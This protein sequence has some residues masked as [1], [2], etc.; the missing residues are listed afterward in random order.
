MPIYEYYC[1]DCQHLF[2]EW[3]KDF[4]EREM[5]CPI[6]GTKAK[7]LIS[8]TSFIL[9]GSGWYVTDYARK[10]SSTS[11]STAQSS[12]N[13]NGSKKKETANQSTDKTEKQDSTKTTTT[14][15]ANS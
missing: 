14:S 2:E 8:N 1:S 13:G 5:N 7:R 11:T 15:D 4:T 10:S 12:D 3:Q 6:C 9:K